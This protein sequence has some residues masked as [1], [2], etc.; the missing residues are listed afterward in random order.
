LFNPQK[1]YLNANDIY[2]ILDL[3]RQEIRKN[4]FDRDRVDWGKASPI[5]TDDDSVVSIEAVRGGSLYDPEL[6]TAIIVTYASGSSENVVLLRGASPPV[7]YS[8]PNADY[9]NNVMIRG[10]TITYVPAG[11]GAGKTIEVQLVRKDGYGAVEKV[12]LIYS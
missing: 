7:H 12:N 10:L 3:I 5:P 6:I 2:P 8:T 11:G 9:I 1:N 4:N